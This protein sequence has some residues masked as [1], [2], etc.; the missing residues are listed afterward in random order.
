MQLKI[1]MKKNNFSFI[2]TI[3]QMEI[4][5]PLD[6]LDD[7]EIKGGNFFNSVAEKDLSKSEI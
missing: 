1:K 2:V 6:D 3:G 4:E 5:I 7:G